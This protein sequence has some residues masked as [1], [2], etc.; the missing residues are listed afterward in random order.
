MAPDSETCMTHRR[1]VQ[2]RQLANED[3][4]YVHHIVLD[5]V[6]NYV[7]VAS[8][9]PAVMANVGVDCLDAKAHGSVRQTETPVALIQRS[10]ST[11]EAASLLRQH[12]DMKFII[13]NL[14]KHGVPFDQILIDLHHS[15][16]KRILTSKAS[17]KCRPSSWKYLASC[18]GKTQHANLTLDPLVM[19]YAGVIRWA[20]M[21]ANV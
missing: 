20:L 17:G 9:T 15:E 12:H 16:G 3:C 10:S 11:S 4:Q 21:N 1:C 14:E 6:V 7:V 8:F 13:E 19:V 2:L 5:E 18:M